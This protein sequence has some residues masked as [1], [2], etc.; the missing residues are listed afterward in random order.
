MIWIAVAE[1][2]GQS[3]LQLRKTATVYIT[4]GN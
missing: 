3:R 2:L 1:Q 4:S